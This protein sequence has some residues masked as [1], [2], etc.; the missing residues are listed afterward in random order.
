MENPERVILREPHWNVPIA[1]LVAGM[2][3][4][5]Q[6]RQALPAHD[7]AWRTRLKAESATERPAVLGPDWERRVMDL[8]RDILIRHGGTFDPANISHQKMGRRRQHG[9]AYE[10]LNKLLKPK[11]LKPFVEQHSNVFAWQPHGQNGM[12]VSWAPQP[13]SNQDSSALQ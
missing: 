11:E 3:D 4:I 2:P 5:R 6:P 12:L 13:C 9:R 10:D 7:N 1:D 8:L